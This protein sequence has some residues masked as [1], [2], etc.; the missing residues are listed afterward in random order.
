MTNQEIGTI[1]N[2]LFEVRPYDEKFIDSLILIIDN[3][4]NNIFIIDQI[5]KFIDKY[6]SKIKDKNSLSKL[7]K[8]KDKIDKIKELEKSDQEN[9]VIDSLEDI[10]K[11]L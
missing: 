1:K 6:I 7:N 11:T 10:L 2:V 9:D 5:S 8:I 3:T 4:K